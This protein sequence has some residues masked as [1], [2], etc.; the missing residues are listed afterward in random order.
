[1]LYYALGV[2][3]AFVLLRLAAWLMQRGLKLVP[4]LPHAGLRNAVKSIY[5]P[6]APARP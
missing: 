6:G 1:M 2:I 5:R 3:A 4:P